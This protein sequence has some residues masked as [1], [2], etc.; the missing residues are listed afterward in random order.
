[1]RTYGLHR[2]RATAITT[3]LRADDEALL[4]E[5]G[6]YLHHNLPPEA[7]RSADPANHPLGLLP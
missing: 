5:V 4:G 7:M 6:A 3:E 2:E 1:M